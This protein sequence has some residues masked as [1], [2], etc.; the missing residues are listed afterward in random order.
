MIPHHMAAITMSRNLLKYTTNIPLQDIAL[1]IIEEQTKSIENMKQILCS[2]RE[3]GNCRQDLLNYQNQMDHIMQE[4][5]SHMEQA[6]ETNQ[7]NANFMREMIPHHMGAVRMSELTLS[8]EIC[9]ALIPILEAIIRSQERG[10]CRMKRLLRCIA[11][12]GFHALYEGSALT[13]FM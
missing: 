8:Y 9:P 5:F 1:G 4:M 3:C 7:L 10:I 6:C 2:C 12:D 11:A 13:F